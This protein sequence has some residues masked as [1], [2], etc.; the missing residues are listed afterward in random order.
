MMK[1]KSGIRCSPGW[2]DFDGTIREVELPNGRKIKLLE[3][4]EGVGEFVDA[5]G[6]DFISTNL[7]AA[8]QDDQELTVAYLLMLEV[9][10]Y[11]SSEKIASGIPESELRTFV[12]HTRDTL[13]ALYLPTA[14]G[15]VRV[16]CQYVM[17]YCCKP[18]IPSQSILRSSR[19]LLISAVDTDENGVIDPGELSHLLAMMERKHGLI[20]FDN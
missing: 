15:F 9:A 3:S 8:A 20:K 7:T 6:T 16:Q 5:V 17:R 10:N 14:T 2:M 18:S 1:T 13:K 19:Y 4:E 11:A 12:K